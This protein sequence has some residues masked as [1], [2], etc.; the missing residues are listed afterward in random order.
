[1][2]KDNNA[3]F[4]TFEA[5]LFTEQ[6]SDEKIEQY[7]ADFEEL[8]DD[9]TGSFDFERM[10]VVITEKRPG[11]TETQLSSLFNGADAD[12]DNLVTYEEFVAAHGLKQETVAGTNYQV[13]Y[14]INSD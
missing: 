7:E 11:I 1:M 13:K 3:N 10:K 9:E 8:D 4:A 2:Q 14:L 5:V 12:D 6:I